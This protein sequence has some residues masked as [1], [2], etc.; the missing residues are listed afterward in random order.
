MSF[1][2]DFFTACAIWREL[3]TAQRRAIA[4]PWKEPHPRVEARLRELLLWDDEG[5]TRRGAVVALLM[6]REPGQLR[7]KANQ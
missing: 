2:L 6:L 4:F 3:T 7:R 1:L 5:V